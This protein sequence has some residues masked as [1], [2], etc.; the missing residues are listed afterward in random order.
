MTGVYGSLF[1]GQRNDRLRRV[2]YNT[3]TLLVESACTLESIRNEKYIDDNG[4]F[5]DKDNP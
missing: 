5:V 3:D 1:V 2:I 4:P